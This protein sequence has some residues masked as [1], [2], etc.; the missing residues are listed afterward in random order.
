MA[1]TWI[2][3]RQATDQYD[4]DNPGSTVTG[5]I[6]YFQTGDGHDGSVFVP[7]ARYTPA[8]VKAMISARAEVLDTI[9]ALAHDS[10][11]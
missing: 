5:V 1:S 6:V 2:V 8:N 9:G 7:Y 11:V 10:Q 3:V 4:P